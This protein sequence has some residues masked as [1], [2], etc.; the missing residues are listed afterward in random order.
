MNFQLIEFMI[1]NNQVSEPITGQMTL[2]KV[3]NDLQ[4]NSDSEFQSELL[5][6]SFFSDDL[7]S[8]HK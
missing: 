6:P 1:S 3:I 5:Y 8:I 7:T 4:I 2:T